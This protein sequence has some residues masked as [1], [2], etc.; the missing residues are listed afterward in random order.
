MKS[1]SLKNRVTTDSYKSKFVYAFVFC[2]T[3]FVSFN[4]F[5]FEQWEFHG[6]NFATISPNFDVGKVED[7]IKFSRSF[8][9]IPDLPPD[10]DVFEDTG[11]PIPK[12]VRETFLEIERYFFGKNGFL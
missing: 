10:G 11:Q 8:P 6:Y 5:A 9:T 7:A 3:I 12:E 1:S 4:L 2:I